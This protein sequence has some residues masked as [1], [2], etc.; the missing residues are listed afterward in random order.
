MPHR[1]NGKVAHLPRKLRGHVNEMLADG[2]TYPEIIDWLASK[3]HPGFFGENISAWKDGGFQDWL[4]QQKQIT[5][6]DGLR[7]L[8]VDIAE[9]CQG[10]KMQQAALYVSAA[11]LYKLLLK[12]NPAK[13]RDRLDAEPERLLT[14]LNCLLR[15]NRRTS[16]VELMEAYLKDEADRRKLD[17]NGKSGRRKRRGL[18]DRSRKKIERD[19]NLR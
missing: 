12:F 16:E 2:A 5:E 8:S 4:D 19:L 17:A 6:L 9:K 3:G 10:S 14:V 15:V 11:F 7:E 13:L 1:R 18:S